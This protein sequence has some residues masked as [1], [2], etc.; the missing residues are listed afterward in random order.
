MWE[1]NLDL[2]ILLR[3]SDALGVVHRKGANMCRG[4]GDIGALH[5]TKCHG[6]ANDGLLVDDGQVG[7]GK[8]DLGEDHAWVGGEWTD[9]GNFPPSDR[10]HDPVNGD[11]RDHIGL[12]VPELREVDGVGDDVGDIVKAEGAISFG[13]DNRCAVGLDE[14]CIFR[15]DFWDERGARDESDDAVG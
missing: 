12:A 2:E 3:G 5:A 1:N 8:S 4:L 11:D 14:I 9:L 10:R 13:L 6:G 7:T 15:D